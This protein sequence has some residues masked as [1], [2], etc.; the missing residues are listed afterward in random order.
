MHKVMEHIITSNIK[1]HGEENSVLQHGFRRER[2][3]Q[4]QL[5]EFLDEI[6][7]NIDRGQQTDVLI[8]DFSTAFDKENHSLLIHKLESYGIGAPSTDGYKT[9]YKEG[10]KL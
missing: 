8:M 7:N 5:I 6:A 9:G 4:T 1:K 10:N 3:C 2:S